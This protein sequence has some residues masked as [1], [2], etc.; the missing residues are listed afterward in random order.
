MIADGL[1]ALAELDEVSAKIRWVRDADDQ[2]G[3]NLPCRA[4]RTSWTAMA[5]SMKKEVTKKKE[6]LVIL[7]IGYLHHGVRR[8]SGVENWREAAT[9]TRYWRNS[10][11]WWRTSP[12]DS[13]Q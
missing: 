12:R 10:S 9:R 2:G 8:G 1:A 3:K 6:A 11:W 5:P 7:Y 13:A 4:T